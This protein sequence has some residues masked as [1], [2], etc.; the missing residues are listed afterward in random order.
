[1]IGH[2]IIAA[3]SVGSDLPPRAIRSNSEELA[4]DVFSSSRLVRYTLVGM[5]EHSCP[6][7]S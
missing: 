3:S 7:N 6:R 1:M 4:N 2:E 5:V